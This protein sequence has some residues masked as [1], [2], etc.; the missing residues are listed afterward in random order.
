MAVERRSRLAGNETAPS[1]STAADTRDSS[2]SSPFVV[3]CDFCGAAPGVQC[4]NDITDR[5]L[6]RA[7][8]HPVRIRWASV[9]SGLDL[10]V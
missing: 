1:K 8:A 9:V 7:L 4:R 3:A 5:P 2:P 10:D 6:T